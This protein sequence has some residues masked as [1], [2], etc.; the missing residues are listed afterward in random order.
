MSEGF[1]NFCARNLVTLSPR[2]ALRARYGTPAQ[3]LWAC[4]FA[5]CWERERDPSRRASPSAFTIG[6][7]T[8]LTELRVTPPRAIDASK[9][10]FSR[11][12]TLSRWQLSALDSRSC[13]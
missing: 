2:Q 13:R 4:H 8:C 1:T 12:G 10:R 9:S 5:N 11:A 6:L 3:K 7:Q